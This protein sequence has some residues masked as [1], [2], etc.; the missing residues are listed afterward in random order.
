[1]T[2]RAQLSVYF[3]PVLAVVVAATAVFSIP[4][5]D[6]LA[7]TRKA[8]LQAAARIQ[9][10]IS[11]PFECNYRELADLQLL[12]GSIAHLS[13]SHIGHRRWETRLNF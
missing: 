7:D 6:D 12:K 13:S 4:F 10:C 11:E 5:L 1:M 9:K 8:G 3:P 2:Q